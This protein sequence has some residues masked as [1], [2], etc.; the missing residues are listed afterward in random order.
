MST[1]P[2]TTSTKP[3]PLVYMATAPLVLITD[4]FGAT[5]HV[6]EASR[7][8]STPHPERSNACSGSASSQPPRGGGDLD[9][10][11]HIDRAV[12]RLPR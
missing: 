4:T 8:P 5:H 2:A 6:Y 7:R 11:G 1:R 10:F 12:Y 3:A 9:F